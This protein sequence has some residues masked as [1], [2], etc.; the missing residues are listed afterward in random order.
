MSNQLVRFVRFAKRPSGEKREILARYRG[1]IWERIRRIWPVVKHMEP[2]FLFIVRNDAVRESVVSGEFEKI[3]RQFVQRFL[4]SGMTVLDVGAYFGIYA[5]T[6]SVKVGPTGRIVAFEPS[7]KQ[8]RGL[9][10]NLFLNC[11]RNVRTE[12]LALSDI[13]G[14]TKFFVAT[15]GAE[16]FSGLRRPEVGAAVRSVDVKTAILD[17]YLEQH[18]IS[19]VDLIKVDVEGGELDFFK[20]ARKLLAQANSPVIL[21]EL[22]DIRSRTWGHTA[23]QTAD[24]VRSFG[25]RWFRPLSGGTLTAIPEDPELYEGNFIG[26][27]PGRVNQLEGL[28]KNESCG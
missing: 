21:C 23:K 3:E 25:Y 15:G 6:A 27:P 2:G 22:E 16:G 9:R 20:G 1:Y 12:K 13:A 28:I 18:A 10:L 14:S 4:K 26:V 19:M 5:L 17:D 11:C 8:M 24:F 7:D